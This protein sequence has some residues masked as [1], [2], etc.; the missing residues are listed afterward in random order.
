MSAA[1]GAGGGH[2]LQ[3]ALSLADIFSGEIDFTND[4]QPGDTFRLLVESA[5]RDDG[6]FGG[7][8]PILAAEIVNQGKRLSALRFAVPGAKP[9]YYDEQGRS[10][11]RFFLKTPLK[12]D[13]RITS[14]F[15]RGRR[16]PV[17]DYVRA[18]NGV[19]YAAPPGAPVAAVANGTV[20]FAGW[21]NGGGRTVKIR[22][23]TGYDSEYLHLSAIAGGVRVGAHVAQGELIGRV[24]ATGLVTG[25]HLHYGLKRNGAY[26]NPIREQS[27]LPP[28]E[29]VPSA[30]RALFD[31]VR[32]RVW[33]LMVTRARSAVAEN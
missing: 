21:T 16:H 27:Y 13:P 25:P 22:H 10:I 2:D 29:P 17:L 24:G 23:A 6:L 8:G 3:L 5:R 18:H 12:F 4:L 26:V 33:Q 20:L 30:Q 15:S 28:G 19:D 9:A 14:G 1:A 7:Y 11:K 31:A 32:E